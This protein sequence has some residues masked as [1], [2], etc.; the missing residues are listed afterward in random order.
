MPVTLVE[1]KTKF[2]THPSAHVIHPRTGEILRDLGVRDEILQS[3]TSPA[4]WRNFIYCASATGTLY[5]TYDHLASPEHRRNQALTDLEIMHFPQHKLVDLLY[6]KLP[7]SVEVRTGTEVVDIKQGSDS[8][9]LYTSKGEMIESEYVLACDGANSAIRGLLGINLKGT[10]V[11][12]TFRSIHFFS[13]QLGKLCAQRPAMITLVYNPK[14]ISGFVTHNVDEGEFIMQVP[15]SPS[16]DKTIELEMEEYKAMINNVAGVEVSDVQIKSIQLWK[17]GAQWAEQMRSQR[18]FLVGDAAHR[19]PPTGGFGMCTGIA[20]A[21]NLCWKLA[22]PEL[23]NTYTPERVG[24]VK[25]I[26][27]QSVARYHLLIDIINSCNLN[28]SSVKDTLSSGEMLQAKEMLFS[29]SKLADFLKD[30]SRMLKLL[31]PEEDLG[32]R[33]DAGFIAPSGGMFCPNFPV[34]HQGKEYRARELPAVVMKEAGKC[35]FVHL[36]GQHA[37]QLPDNVPIYEVPLPGQ[38]SYVMRPDALLYSRS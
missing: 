20:D 18:T 19:M 37:T 8:V 13:K 34:K 22:F 10:D 29:D 25:H 1:R 38:D 28:Y 2:S 5:R 6:R 14:I 23:L 27:Q 31:F 16:R 35:Q 7:P 17:M 9:T 32:Y 33:L 15:F 26:V 24:I 12:Q 4:N 36:K 3:M 30:D 11:I 21:S